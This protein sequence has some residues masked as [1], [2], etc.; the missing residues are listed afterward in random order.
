MR[1]WYRR[2]GICAHLNER[3]DVDV[4]CPDKLDN[5]MQHQYPEQPFHVF[6]VAREIHHELSVQ[7][8]CLGS[9]ESQ[10]GD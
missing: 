4:V 5:G 3:I 9:S 2:Y 1:V 7:E 10:T 8:K 6:F